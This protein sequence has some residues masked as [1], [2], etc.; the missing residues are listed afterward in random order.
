MEHAHNVA[1]LMYHHVAAQG[2]SL[3]VGV[4]QFDSQIRGLAK[5]GYH[6]MSAEEFAAFMAGA[7]APK[8]S[9]LIT[10]DDGYLDNWVYAHPVLKEY[11]MSAVLFTI[12]GLLGDGPV[13]PH[14]GQGSEVPACLPHQQA[15]AQMFGD[16]PDSVML[17]WDEIEAMRQAGTFEVHSHTHTHKRWDLICDT[18][19]E[20]VERLTHDLERSRDTLLQRLGHV[21]SHL[22]WPQGYFDDDYQRVAAELGFDYLYTTDARG[23]NKQH[24]DAGHIY[25]FAVRNRPYAWL[26]QR[27]WLATHRTLGPLYNAWKARG[28]AKKARSR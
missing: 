18:A 22:C 25:R 14:F 27:T 17:R 19:D 11:G 20:K 3:T 7:S 28:D 9:I 8:K 24:G 13:R 6:T 4:D 23:Q 1:V 16:N 12:T 15:K 21:S 5:T 10:F 26:Q 2:G